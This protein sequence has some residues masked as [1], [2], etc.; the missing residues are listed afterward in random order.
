M[1]WGNFDSGAVQR[2]LPITPF[3]REVDQN[4]FHPGQQRYEKMISG[5]YVAQICASVFAFYSRQ[6]ILPPLP[7]EFKFNGW[8]V[9][10]LIED[11][12]GDLS[13]AKKHIQKIWGMTLSTQD[14]ALLQ[15]I[16]CRVTLR[17]ARLAAMGIAT[18]VMRMGR[19]SGCTVSI[20][21]SLY[22]K[23]PNFARNVDSAIAELLGEHNV[24]CVLTSDG[25]GIGAGLIAG[26]A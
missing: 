10:A 25:S 8:D 5:L 18:V 12:T 3:D 11:K 24:K 14:I 16:C 19:Q 23:T 26:L 17:A 21:G 20:D 9:T 7:T 13:A 15:D 22:S 4:S 6:A 2:V 1:E